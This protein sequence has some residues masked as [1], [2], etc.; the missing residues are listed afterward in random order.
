MKPDTSSSL[1]I[2]KDFQRKTVE[3]VFRRLYEEGKKRFLI[4]DEVGLGKTLVARGVVARG[5][6]YIWDVTKGKKRIDIIYICSNADIARQNINRLKVFKSGKNDE[7]KSKKSFATR[8]TLLPLYLGDLENRSFNFV[9]FTPGTSF[10]LQSSGGIKKERALLYHMLFEAWDFGP[11]AA[12]K[13]IFQ[14]GVVEREDWHRFLSSFGSDLKSGESRIDPGLKEAFI[15]NLKKDPKIKKMYQD[16]SDRFHHYRKP[17]NIPDEDREIQREF[18]AALR[19]ILASTCVERLQPAI[20]ILDEFQR[21]RDLL[22]GQDEAAQLAQVLFNYGKAKILL[23]SATPYKPYTLYSESNIDEHYE[24]FLKTV[25]FLFD[26]SEKELNDFKTTLQLY[27]EELFRCNGGGW[28]R[29]AEVKGILQDQLSKVM[30]RTERLSV[31]LDRNGMVHEVIGRGCKMEPPDL[32][33]FAVLDRVTHELKVGDA[34]EYWKSAPYI[35]NTM[36]RKG[37]KIKKDFVDAV[38]QEDFPEEFVSSLG[39][40]GFLPWKT[41]EAYQKLDPGNARMRSLFGETLDRGAWKLLWMPPTFPYYSV[42][43]GPYA[44][45]NLKDFSKVLVFSSWQIVPK[46]IGLLASYEAER[47]MIGGSEDLS[48]DGEELYSKGYSKRSSLLEFTV[49]EGR[50]DR[51][52]NLALFYPCWTMAMDLDPLVIAAK[53]TKDGTLPNSQ[54]V[55]ESLRAEIQSRLNP[56]IRKHAN[57]GRKDPSWYWVA[58]ALLDKH[59]HRDIVRAWLTCNENDLCW[60]KMV[61]AKGREESRFAEY[62][63]RFIEVFD[64]TPRIGEPPDDLFDVLAKIALGSPAIVLLR[65]L[66][67]MVKRED[68]AEWGIQ[69]LG[70]AAKGALG[71]RTLFNLPSSISMLRSQSDSDEA[72]YWTNVIDYCVQGNLQATMDEYF[73]ILREALGLQN[74]EGDKVITELAEAVQSA[75]SIRTVNLDIDEI[76]K[77]R[78]FELVPHSMRCRFALRF[79][80]GQGDK[81]RG[82]EAETRKEQVREAFN[83]PFWPFVLASTSV[84]QEGLDFHQ[85]CRKI[86]HWN[87]PSNP[88]DLE[89]REGRIHRYKGHAIRLNIAEK[90][91][92]ERMT[93]SFTHLCDPWEILFKLAHEEFHAKGDYDDLVP[94]WVF[95]E[96]K[97]KIERHIPIYPFSKD[98]ERLQN[99]KKGLVTYRLVFGQPRQEDLLNFIQSELKEE[100]TS[101]TISKCLIDLSPKL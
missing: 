95:P 61:A 10:Q 34:V 17:G 54:Q 59:Y 25:S 5:I 96:G 43:T 8:L 93:E 87:L 98:S 68:I 76:R 69:L 79:G 65:S 64:R 28:D 88:V 41:I 90:Y 23:L 2:L 70:S 15:K 30:V 35:L 82:D 1:A 92:L 26:H 101:E 51:L 19:C 77:E 33:S 40:N 80:D 66:V 14:Y 99:L 39:K 52:N 12:P 63:D 24:D 21:F 84:G 20:I 31:G 60:N 89:Q 16:L 44:G 42:T 38:K 100:I 71:F 9:S 53:L 22:Q 55:L 94:F 7:G 11:Q 6:D 78:R 81:E 74:S 48:E 73:H 75:V 13:N 27:R 56:I 85:Y 72:V 97:Q 62:V 50:L 29:L 46:V 83:S 37:Y 18:I 4:A 47:N 58:L 49:K 36:D 91:S 32:H 67:R 45:P 3:Y 57:P 86:F